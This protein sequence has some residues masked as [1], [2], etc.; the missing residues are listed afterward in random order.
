MA[1]AIYVFEVQYLDRKSGLHAV[2][3]ENYSANSYIDAIKKGLEEY[4]SKGRV[5]C[6][7]CY[8][9]PSEPECYTI[10]SF[11][12]DTEDFDL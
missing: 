11:S 6:Y 4:E 2:A 12:I 8:L 10:H 5:K 9:K 7:K 1:E 3:S